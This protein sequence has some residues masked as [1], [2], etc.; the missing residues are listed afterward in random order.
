MSTNVESKPT[1]WLDRL[2]GR[3]FMRKVGAGAM[4][5]QAITG[6]TSEMGFSLMPSA[7]YSYAETDEAKTYTPNTFCI[8]LPG[9][10]ITRLARDFADAYQPTTRQY[11][12]ST[13][14]EYS[15]GGIS[16]KEL[17]H[18]I[19]RYVN[20]HAIPDR[21]IQLVVIASSMGGNVAV[22][23]FGA[24]ARDTENTSQPISTRGL[25]LDSSPAGTISLKG[26]IQGFAVGTMSGLQGKPVHGI[27]EPPL[28]VGFEFASR[29][30]NHD[31]P[32]SASTVFSYLQDGIRVA[33][34]TKGRL[35]M[36][37]MNIINNFD[38]DK[39]DYGFLKKANAVIVYTHADTEAADVTVQWSVASWLWKTA[40]ARQQI[41]MG[42]IAIKDGRH[43]N[44]NTAPDP[45][46]QALLS[47]LKQTGLPS[48]AD[49]R[50]EEFYD[51]FDRV[52]NDRLPS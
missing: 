48:I 10:G 46:N 12:R 1:S 14:L 26:P 39:Q 15:E 27:C 51:H 36:D 32:D 42:E 8:F 33:N 24:I 2:R 43:A 45:Y 52:G 16:E 21:P 7:V 34:E 18:S 37:E 35:D 28:R 19:R 22:P 9:R 40:L 30:V 17:E 13:V 23:V 4:A 3:K 49:L 50:R 5:V 6:I 44:P 11:C 25:L 29:A 20:D 47:L 38:P 31:F 41:S